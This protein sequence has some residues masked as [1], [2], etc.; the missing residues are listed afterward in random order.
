MP[1]ASPRAVAAQVLVA[2]LHDGQYLDAALRQLIPLTLAK[3]DASLVREL[4]YGTLRFLPRLEFW[5]SQLLEQSLKDRDR[6]IQALLVLGL[7]QLTEMRVPAHAAVQESAEAARLLHKPWAVKLVNA[8]LRRFQR[9]QV[10]FQSDLPRHAAAY[11]AHPDWLIERIQASWPDDWQGIL[12]ANNARPPLTL[13]VNRRATTRD[14]LLAEFAAAGIGA[15][16]CEFSE[17]GLTLAKPL[18]VET[19]P[20][21][22]AGKFS[23]QDEA[24]QLAA[25]L[26]DIHAGM[27]VLDACA[28]PGGKTCHVLEHCPGAQVLALDNDAP[29]VQKIHQNLQ[30]LGLAAEVKVADATR[31][32]DW[33]DRRPFERILLDAPCSATGVIRRH[34]DIKIRRRPQ[35]IAAATALQGR[36]LTALW[37]LLARGGKLL[38]ATCSVLDEENARQ[39]QT[40]LAAHPDA[41]PVELRCGWGVNAPPGRQTLTGRNRMDGF[42]YA[43]LEKTERLS[44]A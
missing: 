25:Q 4:C 28:A 14:G 3:R 13:R 32:Q 37:P 36:L 8:V 24:A 22:G 41:R 18:D 9:E 15:Q 5:V 34:P 39:A 43:C 38:Y 21:F 30:R 42:Y 44:D 2:V 11:Y 7:Y 29:R 35:D 23:V 12:E 16:A 20:G 33:W 40:F 10:Q 19:L 31:P 17:A 1:A 6:D 26:L 27:R